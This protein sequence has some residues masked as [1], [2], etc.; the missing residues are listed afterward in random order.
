[1]KDLRSD[2]KNNKD[3]LDQFRLKQDQVQKNN[4]TKFKDM[5]HDIVSIKEYLMWYNQ[6]LN[7]KQNI[8]DIKEKGNKTNPNNPNKNLKNPINVN[9]QQISNPSLSYGNKEVDSNSKTH[10]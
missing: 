8:T 6:Q 1:V 3:Q 7:L 9:N 5:T 10:I 2:L 4:S